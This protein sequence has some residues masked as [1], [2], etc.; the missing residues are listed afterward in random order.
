MKLYIPIRCFQK[1]L[2]SHRCDITAKALLAQLV[3]FHSC[4]SL[5]QLATA[6][7]YH[8]A[9]SRWGPGQD[10]SPQEASGE[11]LPS[12]FPLLHEIFKANQNKVAGKFR[13]KLVKHFFLLRPDGA[14]SSVKYFE[15]L[16]RR[17]ALNL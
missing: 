11:K 13:V 15:L 16:P 12:E 14:G 10:S 4:A 3:A 6:D 7:H 2:A 5:P 9:G 8:G 17:S 1:A